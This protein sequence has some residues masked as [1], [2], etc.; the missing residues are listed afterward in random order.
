MVEN[1][2]QN[3]RDVFKPYLFEADIDGDIYELLSPYDL[4]QGIKDLGIEDL[5]KIEITYLMKVLS[6]PE[7]EGNILLIELL[8]IM[9][10]LTLQGGPE[11]QQEDGQND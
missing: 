5:Q 7:L 3:V 2:I 9:D 4:L 11:E 8:Q 1:N 6:K 10:S